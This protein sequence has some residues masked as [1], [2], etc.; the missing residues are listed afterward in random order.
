M[1]KEIFNKYKD[2]YKLMHGK[3][4][5]SGNSLKEDYIPLIKTLVNKTNSKTALD[6][7]CG[8]ARMYK[9]D[10]PINVAF[11]IASENM[12][13]YDIG[14]EEYETLP[15]GEFDGIICTDVL[16]HVPEI[17][18]DD[19]LGTIFNK[20]KKFV[21]FTISC[22]L[23]AKTLPNGE[24]AHVTVKDPSWWNQKLKPYY[25]SDKLV[26]IKFIIPKEPEL[27]ILKLCH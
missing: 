5:F 19:T 14:V 9:G 8:K 10:S 16:E 27:N 22:G 18:L 25:T 4:L 20:S 1:T 15:E 24:N 6:F 3:R 11:G 7:G 12:K 17:L 21:F 2:Q 13:F 23:A 26:H